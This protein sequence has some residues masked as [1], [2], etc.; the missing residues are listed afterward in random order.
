MSRRVA[1]FCV[2]LAVSLALL[3]WAFSQIDTDGVL[4]ALAAVDLR[5][6]IGALAVLLLQYPLGAYR[7]YVI[8][9]A[10]GAGVNWREVLR[11]HLVGIFF[12]Q[13]LPSA[14]GGDAARVWMMNRRA[15]SWTKALS[16]VLL[17]RVAFLVVLLVLLGAMLPFIRSSLEHGAVRGSLTALV[18]IGSSS[19]IIGLL[20]APLIAQGLRRFR[21]T[22]S[23]AQLASDSVIL[24]RRGGRSLA[25]F[26]VGIGVQLS[27][28]VC[29]WML[30]M[31][32][33]VEI[34][35]GAVVA[36]ILPVQLAL[37][38]PIS[39]AGW[40]VREGAMVFGLG[41][42]GVPS[43]LGL[44]ISVLWGLLALIGGVGCWLAWF[45]DP[46]VRDE[47]RGLREASDGQTERA[48]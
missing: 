9:A 48:L 33:G 32:V 31:A 37:A 24:W 39:V 27:T 26:L 15:V 30:A 8:Q 10:L 42:A 7:W 5:W 2:K 43:E 35:F 36:V 3:A 41:L 46:R 1:V 16:S 44:V 22:R 47:A 23:L 38:V 19:L 6:V 18:L 21:W 45:R 34:P 29:V 28:F 17:D 11:M 12:N 13:V 25:I 14:I 4:T 20:V 40:G